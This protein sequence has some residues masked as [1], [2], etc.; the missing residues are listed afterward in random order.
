METR[1]NGVLKVLG[2]KVDMGKVWRILFSLALVAMFAAAPMQ[3]VQAD[4]GGARG[5][6]FD[7]TFTKWVTTLPANPPSNAGILM[8]GVVGGDVGSGRFA[9]KVLSDNLTVPG[10]WLANAR[11]EFYGEEHSFVA[12]VHVTENDMTNPAT[13]AITGVITQGWLK[14]AN[15]TGKYTVMPVCPIATPGNVFGTLCFQGSL[16]ITR[17]FEL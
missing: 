6:T 3:A 13:A 10:F 7:V 4:A 5:H 8:I 9:G 16:H 2:M 17:G 1:K 11:Y 14:G 12:D 15:L